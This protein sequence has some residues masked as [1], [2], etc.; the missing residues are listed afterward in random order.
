MKIFFHLSWLK[1]SAAVRRGFKDES[2]RDLFEKYLTRISKFCPCTSSGIYPNDAASGAGVKVWVCDRG[3]GS[4]VLSSEEVA[5]ALARFQ[6]EGTKEWH[7][8]IGGPDGFSKETLADMRPERL[9][10]F[11]SLT[12]PHELAT[13]VASEQVYRAW[14]IN[15]NLPYHAAH[16]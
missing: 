9:W 14:T 16:S 13:V 8:L 7:I 1:S 11:G 6:N 12:L 5:A 3:V 2:A 10:S 4:R 15:R